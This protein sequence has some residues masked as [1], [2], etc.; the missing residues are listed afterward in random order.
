MTTQPPRTGKRE[1]LLFQ[2]AR[3]WSRSALDSLRDRTPHWAIRGRSSAEL[4]EQTRSYSEVSNRSG[5]EEGCSSETAETGPVENPATLINR[6]DVPKGTI[7]AEFTI[8]IL[9][10]NGGQL[11]WT[12]LKEDL[13][14]SNS[15]SQRILG[16]LH[17]RG[18]VSVSTDTENRKII[19][20]PEEVTVPVLADLNM[21]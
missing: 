9:E 14:W 2:R 15:A 10:G 17:E 16:D 21:G 20:L 18:C 7:P 4:R 1:R 8:A 19:S 11:P 13:G 12:V 6:P 3:E 5:P